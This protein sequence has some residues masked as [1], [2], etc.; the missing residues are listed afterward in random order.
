MGTDAA[1][2]RST[3]S[4]LQM[5]LKSQDLVQQHPSLSP[6]KETVGSAPQLCPLFDWLC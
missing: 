3:D 4:T 6:K 2:A 5:L 1:S